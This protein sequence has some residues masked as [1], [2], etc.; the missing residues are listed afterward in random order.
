MKTIL[1]VDDESRMLDLLA[2]YLTPL[3][4]KCVK[5]SSAVDAI[6]YIE[7]N[8]A[9]LILLDVMMPEMD[10]WTACKEFKKI[11]D[12]PIIMLTARSEKPDIVK[13]LKIGADDYILKPF[14]EEVLVARIEAVL[15]RTTTEEE[16]L[17]FKGLLLKPA[18]YELYFEDKEIL[19]TPKEFAMVQLFISNRNKVFSRDHLIESVWGYGVSIED[20]TIDSHVRN[21]REKLRRAGFPADEF[22]LTVWGVGYKW[23]G[24]E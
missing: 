2:L 4:Y 8:H 12:I 6:T 17:S 10:G 5:K 14:D 23:T 15:R 9:D 1:L 24:K 11:R 13:G 19:L 16:F 21:I 22:L 3:G 7:T 20:R 18:S